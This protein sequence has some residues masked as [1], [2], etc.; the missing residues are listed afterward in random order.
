LLCCLLLTGLVACNDPGGNTP[1][2]DLPS[3]EKDVN[4]IKEFTEIMTAVIEE[5]VGMAKLPTQ[6][7]QL[8]TLDG[9]IS[10]GEISRDTVEGAFEYLDEAENKTESP[11]YA[12][13]AGTI[14][15]TNLI[16]VLAYAQTLSE[17][18]EIEKIYDIPM[19]IEPKT[20]TVDG[21][22]VKYSGGYAIIKSDGTRKI[23]YFYDKNE[24]NSTEVVYKYD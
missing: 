3:G 4:E 15:V 9:S 13:M 22:E 19:R 24:D 1:S 10:V 12:Q 20:E 11:F 5:F 23:L 18:H 14:A 16:S 6:P 17:V 8:A 2:G 7:T 21:E